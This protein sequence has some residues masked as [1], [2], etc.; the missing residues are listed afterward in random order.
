MKSN[1]PKFLFEFSE[2]NY[3]PAAIFAISLLIGCATARSESGFASLFDG[4]TLKGWTLVGKNGPGYGATNGVMF[5]ARGGGGNLFTEREYSDFVLR[6]DYKLEDG[7]NNGVGI[8]APL[9]G[10]AAY[11]GMEIQIL[12]DKAPKHANIKPWQFN[13]SV[14]NIV[15]AKNGTPKIGEWNSY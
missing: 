6:L 15:P 9:E 1:A 7:S 4:H 5:C 2:L 8:R 14:Y 11:A 13:G 10:D 3:A 12:D